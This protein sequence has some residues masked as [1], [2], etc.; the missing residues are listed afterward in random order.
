M[1]LM[2]I[3]LITVVISGVAFAAGDG[4]GATTL[5]APA[6]NVFILLVALVFVLKK[7]AREFFASKSSTVSEMIER[8]SSKAKE[9]E[10]MMEIQKKKTSNVDEEIKTL[11]QE[12]EKLLKEFETAYTADVQ[13]RIKNM[14]V[15][16]DNKI[17]S[18]KK[19]LVEELNA[20]LLDL[21]V[22]KAKTQ[23]KADA[24]LGTSATEKIIKGL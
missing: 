6:T 22:A 7:P 10:A 5:I 13:E 14:K 21:V 17:E 11:K 20:N 15:D 8:A 1:K 4:H 16:A 9:A 2:L 18:E 24:S 12:S 19:E 3:A 23:I